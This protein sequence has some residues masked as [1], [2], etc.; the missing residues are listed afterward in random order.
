MLIASLSSWVAALCLLAHS[1]SLAYSPPPP[2]GGSFDHAGSE[3]AVESVFVTA[4]ELD[5]GPRFLPLHSRVVI[6][7]SWVDE[8]GVEEDNFTVVDFLP[9]EPSRASTVKTLLAGGKVPGRVRVRKVS[10]S[11]ALL[12]LRVYSKRFSSENVTMRDVD[13]FVEGWKN[14]RKP[15]QILRNNCWSFAFEMIRELEVRERS[16][17]RG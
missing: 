9:R 17:T 6:K 7:S 14:G 2:S 4:T 11:T 12:G 8:G 13:E 15:L 16:N 10:P 5:N 1:S 3:A